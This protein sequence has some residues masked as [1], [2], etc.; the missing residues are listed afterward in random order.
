MATEGLIT[1]RSNHG[2]EVTMNRLEAQ[3]RDSGMELLAHI[4]HAAGAARA[5]LLLRPT[6]LLIFGAPAS[7]TPL[8]QANQAAGIDLPMKV[9]VWQ[10]EAGVTWL[11]YND[12]CWIA[13]R[14]GL[15][16][17]LGAHAATMLAQLDALARVA[18]AP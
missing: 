16:A 11:C 2:P 3:V 18:I 8:M 14:H 17:G 9:L 15:D 13:R 4:D 10:D 6:D 5:G 7:R 1:L 12:P